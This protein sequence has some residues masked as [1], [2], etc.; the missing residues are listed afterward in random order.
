MAISI[1]KKEKKTLVKGITFD[2]LI[3]RIPRGA[4]LLG[5]TLTSMRILK[6]VAK[7]LRLLEEM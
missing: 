7:V 1:K 5:G 3:W 4:V 2:H 6:G